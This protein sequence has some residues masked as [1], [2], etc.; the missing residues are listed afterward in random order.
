[1]DYQIE[2]FELENEVDVEDFE[3]GEVGIEDFGVDVVYKGT[4]KQIYIGD[5]EPTDPEIL[6]WIDT[7]GDTPITGT[8]LLTSDNKKFITANDEK[9]ILKEV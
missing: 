3:L 4:V 8:Q 1:M 5:E 9:F 7:S 2:D 6:I